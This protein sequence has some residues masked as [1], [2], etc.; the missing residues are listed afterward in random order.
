MEAAEPFC[1]HNLS[2]RASSSVWE[3]A[4]SEVLKKLKVLMDALSSTELGKSLWEQGVAPVGCQAQ[5]QNS[6]SPSDLHWWGEDR[7]QAPV[8]EEELMFGPF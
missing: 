5:M 3:H 8:W 7:K 6:R 2:Q 1:H 4:D